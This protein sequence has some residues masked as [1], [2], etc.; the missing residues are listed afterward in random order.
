MGS[1]II[2]DSA[3]DFYARYSNNT[4]VRE[5]IFGPT[6]KISGDES[7]HKHYSGNGEVYVSLDEQKK[8]K[9]ISFSTKHQSNGGDWLNYIMERDYISNWIEGVK[10]LYQYAG[11]TWQPP[12]Y[13]APKRKAEPPKKKLIIPT[14]LKCALAIS[15]KT[16]DSAHNYLLK[17]K[18]GIDEAIEMGIGYVTESVASLFPD[19]FCSSDIGR[20]AFPVEMKDSTFYA[21]RYLHEIKDESKIAK[22]RNT[23]GA[24]KSGFA[25]EIYIGN[26][27]RIFLVEGYKDAVVLNYREK[28]ENKRNQVAYL[29]L[30]GSTLTEGQVQTLTEIIDTKKPRAIVFAL[31]AD[32]S[33]YQGTLKAVLTLMPILSSQ[34]QI[35]LLYCSKWSEINK[36]KIVKD[37]AELINSVGYEFFLDEF[38]TVDTWDTF[39]LNFLLKTRIDDQ[40]V[41]KK[42]FN[43]IT[44]TLIKCQQSDIDR[45]CKL[46]ETSCIA[47]ENVRL[48]F[49]QS[50]DEERA[51]HLKKEYCENLSQ[52]QKNLDH[53]IKYQDLEAIAQLKKEYPNEPGIGRLPYDTMEEL[54]QDITNTPE[55]LLTYLSL[56]IDRVAGWIP[57]SMHIVLGRPANGKTS[58]MTW[59][60]LMQLQKSDR[61]IVFFTYEES[62]AS[63]LKKFIM[64]AYGD[65]LTYLDEK[66]KVKNYGGNKYAVEHYISEHF[67]KTLKQ[68]DQKLEKAIEEVVGYIESGRLRLVSTVKHHLPVNK[69]CEAVARFKKEEST[70]LF[71]ADYLQL[72][73]PDPKEKS[74]ANW[75]K[76][77]NISSAIRECAKDVQVPIILGAQ[78]GREVEGRSCKIPYASDIRESGDVEQD[79]YS[80]FAIRKEERPDG[81]ETESNPYKIKPETESNPYKIKIVKNRGGD[82][83]KVSGNMKTYCL[84]FDF[85][86]SQK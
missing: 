43:L 29:G 53:A 60:A 9:W 13:S 8:G 34:A 25:G 79:A 15:L 77:K 23:Q 55:K 82:M 59:I 5:A 78:A 11:E 39:L 80:I 38:A 48:L 46:V 64:Q 76:M 6:I 67:K 12:Q 75:L 40:S 37:P 35:D 51:K 86:D 44:E 52:H 49:L 47:S 81:P 3:N 84:H 28:Q 57:G 72:I 30:G 16:S 14:D 4:E 2:N 17:E 68:K 10:A 66:S 42:A 74:E 71:L 7:I 50:L 32:N 45:F 20:I 58:I 54:K 69:F 56:E 21:C 83:V 27:N 26:Q 63:L 1:T 36:K 22:Y 61:K 24:D 65:C 18:I 73:P 85:D 33:G 41:A 19:I 62:S 70:D 31:D